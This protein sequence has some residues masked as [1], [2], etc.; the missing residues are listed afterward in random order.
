MQHRRKRFAKLLNVNI[1][2]STTY[3]PSGGLCGKHEWFRRVRGDI[4]PRVA[5]FRWRGDALRDSR[6]PKSDVALV[7]GPQ[8]R[9]SGEHEE[10]GALHFASTDTYA[11]SHDD[12]A[13]ERA[14]PL[15][16]DGGERARIRRVS[17]RAWRRR[18]ERSDR[19]GL[20][21]PAA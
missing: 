8:V 12:R 21:A 5:A 7:A 13:G 6:R 2:S 15:S 4:G 16:P 9:G 11:H 18:R 17:R 3:T 14:R 10:F 1:L 20:R 19:S